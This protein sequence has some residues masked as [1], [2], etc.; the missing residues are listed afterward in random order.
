MSDPECDFL[1]Q[2]D[3]AEFRMIRRIMIA[4]VLGTDMSKHGKQL[5]YAQTKLAEPHEDKQFALTALLHAADISH[6]TRPFDVSYKW[7]L[8][9]QNEFFNQGDREKEL[10][11]EVTFICDREKVKI[12]GC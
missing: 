12:P 1:K 5:A 11:Q 8:R 2:I 10:G 6:S 7:T 9:V 4:C 3:A